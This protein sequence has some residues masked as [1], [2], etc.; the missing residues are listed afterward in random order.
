MKFSFFISAVLLA[1]VIAGCGPSDEDKARVKLNLAQSLLEKN[2][3]TAA[4]R[5]LD[6]IPRLYPKAVYALNAA[7][8]LVNEVQFD[9]LHRKEAELDSLKVKVAELEKPFNKEKTEFD[10]YTQYVHKRQTFQRAWDRSYIQVHLDERGEIY[11][12]SNYHGEKWLDHTALR[13]YDQGDDAKT[14]EI[15]IGSPDNHRSDFMEAKWEKV[16][17]R[18]GK[19]NGV[20]EFIANNADRNLKA[21]FL[22]NKYYYIILETY[23]K[24]AVKDALALSKAL[25]QRS[26][27]QAEINSLQ[28]Q[29]NIS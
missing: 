17:Y 19:D 13:V 11:L 29:L 21:V 16:S 24:Q 26:K 10:R 15:P 1:L 5:H 25:K 4:L 3:T 7:K 23:D 8:N 12:S 9:L 20:M 27:L 6:S 2:D 28:K 18:N 14:E 22:G